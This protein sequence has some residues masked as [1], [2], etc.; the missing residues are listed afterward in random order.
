MRRCA[1]TLID[2]LISAAIAVGLVFAFQRGGLKLAIPWYPLII[3]WGVLIAA[4]VGISAK[5]LA[6]RS[7]GRRIT[8][9]Y[10]VDKEGSVPSATRLLNR[11]LLSLLSVALFGAGLW[12]VIFDR[13]GRS[14]H[15]LL[16][17]TFLIQKS[18]G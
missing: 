2:L 14:L 16:T 11:S 18:P 4:Q 15:D 9:L 7:I 13:R 5:L 3:L 8:G 12:L 1:A 17:G 6:G 10:I